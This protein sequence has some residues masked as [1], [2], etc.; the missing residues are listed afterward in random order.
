MEGS[1]RVL[2]LTDIH[3]DLTYTVG[4]ETDCGLPMCCG[5]TSAQAASASTAA[6][7]WGDYNCDIPAW[8][9]NKVSP[10]PPPESENM[11]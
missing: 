4:S 1:V 6:G 5:N 10:P 2:H 3:I 8:T 11:I 7:Q 9:Y